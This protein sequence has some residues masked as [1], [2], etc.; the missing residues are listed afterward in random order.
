MAAFLSNR[1]DV[2]LTGKNIAVMKPRDLSGG[3]NAVM[4][5]LNLT[6]PYANDAAIRSE[7]RCLALGTTAGILTNH[8]LSNTDRCA[9]R[10]SVSPPP[11]IQDVLPHAASARKVRVCASPPY[12]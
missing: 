1:G 11:S 5:D 8:T 9:Q 7:G 3:L 6:A 4:H 10:V 12:S 2:R